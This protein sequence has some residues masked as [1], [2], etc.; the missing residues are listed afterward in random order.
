VGLEP[1]QRLERFGIVQ[2]MTRSLCSAALTVGTLVALTACGGTGDKAPATPAGFKVT[3][4]KYFAFAHPA[5]WRTDVR[6]PRTQA[7]KD[8]MVAEAVG[9]AMTTGKRPDVVVGVTPDY[10]SGIDGLVT[11]NELSQ[12]TRYADRRVLSR[13][14]AHVAGAAKAKLIESEIPAP[15]G[16][17]IRTFDLLAISDKKTA[18]NMFVAVPAADVDRARIHDILRTLRVRV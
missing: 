17:P 5:A 12:K 16:T 14:D 1:E 10:Q 4:T 11:V 6:K 3:Q 13:K 9:P 15:D 2:D 8:E 7:F 18:V